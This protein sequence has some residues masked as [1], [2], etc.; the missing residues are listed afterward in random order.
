MIA[1]FYHNLR[2]SY[3][4]K[5]RRLCPGYLKYIWEIFCIW[6]WV[7]RGKRTLRRLMRFSPLI[8]KCVFWFPLCH[9]ERVW[10]IQARI[11]RGKFFSSVWYKTTFLIIFSYRCC[12]WESAKEKNDDDTHTAISHWSIDIENDKHIQECPA[13]NSTN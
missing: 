11:F 8:V 9:T 3:I 6:I 12:S 2:T 5:E 13:T 4:F 7:S 10:D 1:L